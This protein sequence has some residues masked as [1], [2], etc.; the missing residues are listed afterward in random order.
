MRRLSTQQL[1]EVFLG[2][3]V[4]PRSISTAWVIINRAEHEKGIDLRH[5]LECVRM[6]SFEVSVFVE[7]ILQPCDL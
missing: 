7:K 3:G 4:N 5:A 1:E 6:Q 2:S